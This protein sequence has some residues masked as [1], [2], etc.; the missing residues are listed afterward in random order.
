MRQ[1]PLLRGESAFLSARIALEAHGIPFVDVRSPMGAVGVSAFADAL[2]VDD[3]DY[4]A[5]VAALAELEHTHDAPAGEAMASPAF[6][7]VVNA[8]VSGIIVLWLTVLL[9]HRP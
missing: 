7:L 3:E 9:H 1:L 8:I 2:L 6:R 4:D 5:A